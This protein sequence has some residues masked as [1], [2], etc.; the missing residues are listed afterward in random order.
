MKGSNESDCTWPLNFLFYFRGRGREGK[1]ESQ[2][3]SCF[4][5]VGL[6][7]G[8]SALWAARVIEGLITFIVT[9]TKKNQVLTGSGRG[10]WGYQD[11]VG[12]SSILKCSLHPSM[13]QVPAN[14]CDCGEEGEVAWLA[15]RPGKG[16]P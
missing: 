15:A 2:L 9:A 7:S 8:F 4:C 5:F 12:V 11:V 16:T 13:G 3:I 1:A 6:C 14:F 10:E